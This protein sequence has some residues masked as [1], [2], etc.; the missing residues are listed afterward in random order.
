MKIKLTPVNNYKM[1]ID[2]V[3]FEGIVSLDESSW[4]RLRCVTTELGDKIIFEPISLSLIGEVLRNKEGN[5]FGSV[6]MISPSLIGEIMSK[7][8]N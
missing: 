1:E 7:K 3:P 4:N 6:V 2:S 5:I 8:D